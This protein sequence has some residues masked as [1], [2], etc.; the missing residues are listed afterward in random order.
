MASPHLEAARVRPQPA[1]DDTPSQAA[2][3][4]TGRR[5]TKARVLPVVLRLCFVAA[6]VA[7]WQV[8]T[9]S[10]MVS[11]L[12]M[13]TPGQ[14]FRALGQIGD[15]EFW[16]NAASTGIT[17]GAAFVIG[18]ATGLCAG[19]IFWR[20]RALGD[21]VE[22]F[23]ITLYST[24]TLVF[25][26]VLIVLFGLN[27]TPLIVIASS[28]VF[29]PIA[30]NTMLG[31]RNLSPVL[32]RLASSCGASP[33]ATFTK[34]LLPG[35]TPIIFAG[36]RLA[37]LYATMGTIAMEMVVASKGLGYKIGYDYANFQSE[38][39]YGLVL[40]VAVGAIVLNA[41]LTHVERGLRRDLS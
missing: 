7:V 25:Y 19:V 8:V 22:P 10:G 32:P 40:V 4:K 30:L 16:V 33:L 14:A 1:K 31:L 37:F 28:M 27:L 6:V 38:N 2:P 15:A 20:Y 41:I 21:A 35:A 5:V 9:S 29:M 13:P 12:T 24:P 17:I 36:A 18:T 34:V 23:L 39:M 3:Q 26:P 11:S